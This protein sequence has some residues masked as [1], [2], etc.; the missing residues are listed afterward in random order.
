MVSPPGGAL[1]LFSACYLD[2]DNTRHFITPT[3]CSVTS[4]SMPP[5][6]GK[7]RQMLLKHVL[8]CK[9][10]I[11]FILNNT[12]M[13]MCMLKMARYSLIGSSL[14]E[15]I[16]VLQTATSISDIEPFPSTTPELSSSRA[17]RTAFTPQQGALGTIDHVTS[18]Y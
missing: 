12:Y 1:C 17:K 15:Q 8:V 4:T 11:K 18:W 2:N 3:S 16:I 10:D 9:K 6:D 13:L 14:M 7:Q 5:D